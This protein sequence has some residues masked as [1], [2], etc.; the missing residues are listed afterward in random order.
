[1]PYLR[2]G[3][4]SWCALK[5]NDF[6]AALAGENG[7]DDQHAQSNAQAGT[8]DG[9][10]HGRTGK[11]KVVHDDVDNNGGNRGQVHIVEPAG[12]FFH[13]VIA[14]VRNLAGGF[15]GGTFGFGGVH[16]IRLPFS[17]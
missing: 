6:I 13:H 16:S 17:V 12:Y 1:M 2:F 4:F 10:Q 9:L 14:V 8:L 15:F 3:Q 7:T 11:I 5:N